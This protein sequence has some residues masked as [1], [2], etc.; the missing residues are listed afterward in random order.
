M[1]KVAHEAHIILLLL[2]VIKLLCKI[3]AAIKKAV[4]RVVKNSK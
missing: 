3:T 1:F 2:T 4:V